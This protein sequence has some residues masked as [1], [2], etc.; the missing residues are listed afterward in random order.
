[1]LLGY[2]CDNMFS[3]VSLDSG[4]FALSIEVFY[5]D[6]VII[7]YF[8]VKLSGGVSIRFTNFLMPQSWVV[9][10]FGFIFP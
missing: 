6:V 2:Y 10:E 9:R 4:S 7:I 5:N 1:M 3:A 8:C